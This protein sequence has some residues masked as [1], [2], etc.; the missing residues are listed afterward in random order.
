MASFHKMG[1]Q[2][3]RLSSQRSLFWISSLVLGIFLSQV[4]FAD[5]D[6]ADLPDTT[7][8]P[9]VKIEPESPKKV[10][11]SKSR[12]YQDLRP[13]WAFEFT[14]SFRALREQAF[15]VQQGDKPAYA[16][17]LHFDYQ[18]DFLQ[19]LGVLGIG[20]SVA[21]YP[22]FGAGITNG[23]FSV[24]SAGGQIRYQ[25]RYF[26]NQPLVPV[27]AY[28]FEN[29]TYHF[30]ESTSGSLLLKGPTLGIWFFLN[31]LEPSSASQS[32]IENGILRSYLVLEMRSLSG[33]DNNFSISGNTYYFGLR[34]EY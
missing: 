15:F 12:S 26:K 31:I 11:K 29:L 7:D 3:R 28:S 34:F 16:F 9:E 2:L 4:T 32:Y 20:P 22:F 8:S 30:I 27:V 33:S 25:A 24:W 14:S 13:N 6:S 1:V 19:D 5:E 23:I 21:A 18:P 10:L 17:S